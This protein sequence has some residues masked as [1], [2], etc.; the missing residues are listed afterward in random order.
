[1]ALASLARDYAAPL[2]PLPSSPLA[3]PVQLRL[4]LF[5]SSSRP[6]HTARP[7]TRTRSAN[8][9]PVSASMGA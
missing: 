3:A 8:C 6:T 5:Q 2:H 4:R 7:I 9:S 1:M